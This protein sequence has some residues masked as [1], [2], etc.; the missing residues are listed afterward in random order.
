MTTPG[1]ARHVRDDTALTS[2]RRH[3]LHEL[4]ELPGPGEAVRREEEFARA[5]AILDLGDRD[6]RSGN[7]PT[8]KIVRLC[9]CGIR[10][11]LE[12]GQVDAIHR[13]VQVERVTDPDF[14]QQ[15]IAYAAEVQ[16]SQCPSDL[17]FRRLA[18]LAQ[19]PTSV[20]RLHVLTE[21]QERAA[22]ARRIDGLQRIG[23]CLRCE[24]GRGNAQPEQRRQQQPP[25]CSGN[26]PVEAAVRRHFHPR[27][28]CSLIAGRAK[29][30]SRTGLRSWP[31]GV[32]Y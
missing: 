29:G 19:P 30:C 13:I 7:C 11:L 25:R 21:G 8:C 3:V 24:A 31:V 2:L 6:L 16:C 15:G 4:I 22:G 9:N 17:D 5:L 27:Q 20:G 32:G 14:F 10:Y 1:A 26:T 12:R 28:P 23:I 18:A